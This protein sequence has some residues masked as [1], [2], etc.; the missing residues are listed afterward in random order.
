MQ[1]SGVAGALYRHV[2][3]ALRA[4]IQAGEPPVG[5]RLP[6]EAQLTRRF[7]VSVITVKRA[8]DMLRADGFIVRRPRVGTVI[9]SDVPTAASSSPGQGSLPL[10]GCVL[11]NFDDTFG[12]HVL[13]GLLDASQTTANLV[14]KRSV[15]DPVREDEAVRGLVAGDIKALVLEPAS[16]EYVPPSVLEL[17]TRG[18]PVVILDRTFD[19]VPVSTVCSDNVD[20]A[21][22]AT[23]HLFS[24]G[25]AHVGLVSSSNRVSTLEDR[26]EG[27]VHAHAEFHVPHE[28]HNDFRLVESTTPGSTRSPEEDIDGLTDYLAE[29]P[30]LTGVVAT[31]YAIANLLRAACQRLGRA[32][33]EQLS[34]VCFDHPSTVSSRV[35]WT[36]HMAQDQERMGAAAV[37]LALELLGGDRRVRK[38][39]LPTTLVLGDSSAPPGAAGPRSDDPDVQHHVS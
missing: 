36:T 31:E 27:F 8:L 5:A 18:F 12:T 33:P 35:P 16:S 7:D 3:E 15:G 1:R 30:H 14:L 39:L 23:E 11:T 38:V 9:V 24:L 17:V 19:G 34:I 29:R 10:V 4:E 6:S 25:H 37:E 28:P 22:R 32:V 2:Y 20:A 21:K 26:A 13:G